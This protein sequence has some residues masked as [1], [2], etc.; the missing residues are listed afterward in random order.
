MIEGSDRP[1]GDVVRTAYADGPAAAQS[2]TDPP[3]SGQELRSALTY[4]ADE[5]CAAAEAYCPGCRKWTD[6][7]GLTRL[8]QFC[9]RF[10]S[11]AFT[12]SGLSLSPG[13]PLPPPYRRFS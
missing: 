11:I 4:C 8:D 3:L 5:A 2:L 1:V 10:S 12:D 13:G 7:E 6:H 9:A